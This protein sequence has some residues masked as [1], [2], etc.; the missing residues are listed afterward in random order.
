MADGQ[1]QLTFLANGESADRV[2]AQLE[3]KLAALEGRIKA[4]AAESKR[5]AKDGG[6]GWEKFAEGITR[7]LGPMAAATT[8]VGLFR[9]EY[10]ALLER[11]GKALEANQNF[12]GAFRQ[13][14]MNLGKDTAI[15]NQE[16]LKEEI[17]RISKATGV[18]SKPVALALSNAFS[19][20]GDLTG[21]QAATAVEA[22]LRM[23]PNVE[24]AQQPVSGAVLDFMKSRPDATAESILGFIKQLGTESRS[25][26]IRALTENTAP[27]VS[28]LM[29]EGAS[30]K[31]AAA[32]VTAMSQATFDVEGRHS[33]TASVSLGRQLREAFPKMKD[34]DSRLELVQ[35]NEK[36]RKVFL[37]GGRWEGNKVAKASFETKSATA[38]EALLSGK[39]D[40]FEN[41]RG[42]RERMPGVT[43]GAPLFKQFVDEMAKEKSNVLDLGTRASKATQEGFRL[44]DT[45]GAQT[46]QAREIMQ[47]GL[48]TAG[49][50][51]IGRRIAGA[52]FSAETMIG[53][54]NPYQAALQE[55]NLAKGEEG[56]GTVTPAQE[57]QINDQISILR[58]LHETML[59]IEANT[60]GAEENM[61]A[62]AR[63][64]KGG[65]E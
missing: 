52:R 8:A 58:A 13:A 4:T 48:E 21:K 5:S 15:T 27:A 17:E 16:E 46:A 11:Q 36:A 34:L 35:T 41:F 23:L 30:D 18:E 20:R 50:S 24:E 19:A 26:D 51:W 37:E 56:S 6:A 33:G 42:A 49:E 1:V 59:K 38:I 64:D 32:I 65:A 14:F 63:R 25:T 31:T 43:E 54:T 55:L 53:G 44:A 9:K 60:K 40:V 2:F 12:A 45:K 29:R 22:T 57:K 62:K 3:R 10:D 39:G 61:A 7:V 28:N 47:T